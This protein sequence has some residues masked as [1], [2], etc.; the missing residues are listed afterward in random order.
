[1]VLTLRSQ[2]VGT[3]SYPIPSTSY[4]DISVLFISSGSAIP[5]PYGSTPMTMQFGQRSLIFRP[6]PVMVPPVPA[7]HTTMSTLSVV[8][9]NTSSIHRDESGRQQETQKSS[10]D[11]Y[12]DGEFPR[13]RRSSPV[14]FT[15]SG[16]RGK[17]LEVGFQLVLL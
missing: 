7:E 5:E 8:R 12:A 1:M 6:I 3:K 14:D 4:P 9:T 17:M 16:N 11:Y 10:R 15:L 2:T 13:K